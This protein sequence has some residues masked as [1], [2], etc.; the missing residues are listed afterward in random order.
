MS[1]S[2]HG[3][4]ALNVMKEAGGDFSRENMIEAVNTRFGGDTRYH[5]CIKENMTAEELVDF[6]AGKNLLVETDNGFSVQAD[7][8]CSC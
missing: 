4:E 2:V 8:P 1:N 6:L 3:L 5:V 7:I